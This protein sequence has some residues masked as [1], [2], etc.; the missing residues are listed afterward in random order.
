M[1]DVH[2]VHDEYGGEMEL[3]SLHEPEWTQRGAGHPGGHTALAQ[4]SRYRSSLAF[5]II[6]I[7]KSR[8]G[9]SDQTTFLNIKYCGQNH[10]RF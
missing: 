1:Q 7:S 6:S 9:W 5:L 3:F 10:H 8:I 4:T 2:I